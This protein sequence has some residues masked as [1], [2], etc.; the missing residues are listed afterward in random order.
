MSLPDFFFAEFFLSVQFFSHQSRKKFFA[1]R[2]RVEI[3]FVADQKKNLCRPSSGF[4]GTGA[5]K[6]IV[7]SAS[8][9]SAVPVYRLFA[10]YR[11]SVAFRWSRYFASPFL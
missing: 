3:F 1:E 11:E 6:T 5:I 7:L 2:I 10:W 9:V 4:P 8:S